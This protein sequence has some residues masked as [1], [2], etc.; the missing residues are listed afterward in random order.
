MPHAPM[1]RMTSDQTRI[2]S[3]TGSPTASS[4]P[5]TTATG[6]RPML[7]LEVPRLGLSVHTAA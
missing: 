1:T 4:R 7:K 6:A 3:Q 2:A 5:N